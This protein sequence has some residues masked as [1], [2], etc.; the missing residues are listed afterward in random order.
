MRKTMLVV[1]AAFAGSSA[2]A[3]D[4]ITAPAD[5]AVSGEGAQMAGS[6]DDMRCN[7]VMQ[8][9]RAE[10]GLPS[11]DRQPATPDEALLVKAVDHE[12]DGC[13]VLL[14]ANG[15]GDIRRLPPMDETAPLLRPAQ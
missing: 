5:P 3:A 2:L 4:A 10:R 15:Q 8:A 9:V 13:D 7:D 14:M 6:T 1:A 12:V 11:V